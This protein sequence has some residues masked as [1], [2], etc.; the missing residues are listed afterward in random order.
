M[1][2]WLWLAKGRYPQVKPSLRLTRGK[3]T[4]ASRVASYQEGAG[5]LLLFLVVLSLFSVCFALWDFDCCGHTL[6]EFMITPLNPYSH[7]LYSSLQW[8]LSITYSSSSKVQWELSIT[9]GYHGGMSCRRP[10]V[11]GSQL[12]GEGSYTNHHGFA[13]CLVLEHHLVDP[14]RTIL[15]MTYSP[16]RLWNLSLRWSDEARA[17]TIIANGLLGMDL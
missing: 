1:P 16:W 5:H 13:L 14:L 6:E 15:I 11:H 2:P 10:G 17:S 4:M 3:S 9:S 7:I 12:D 8:E